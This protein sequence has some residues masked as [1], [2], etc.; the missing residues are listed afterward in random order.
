MNV[1]ENTSDLLLI[2]EGEPEPVAAQPALDDIVE[3][4]EEDED[5]DEDFDP[6]KCAEEE[7]DEDE[8][9]DPYAEPVSSTAER[10]QSESDQVD[11]VDIISRRTRSNYNVDDNVNEPLEFPDFSPDLYAPDVDD[12][13]YKSFL[14]GLFADDLNDIFGDDNDDDNDPEFLMDL[15]ALTRA[16]AATAPQPKVT[17]SET[18]RLLGDDA[19]VDVE[20]PDNVTEWTSAI[21]A[22]HIDQIC[23]QMS[24]HVQLLTQTYLMSYDRPAMQK[25][26]ATA[27]QLLVEI[28]W[29]RSNKLAS[30]FNVPNLDGALKIVADN[31]RPTDKKDAAKEVV[32]TSWRQPRLSEKVQQTISENPSAFPCVPLLPQRGF[33]VWVGDRLKTKTIYTKAEDYLIALGLEQFAGM[34]DKH[35]YIHQLL[36]PT[37]TASQIRF[38][39]KNLRRRFEPENAL[40]CFVKNKPLP[41]IMP[42]PCQLEKRTSYDQDF[43]HLPAWLQEAI[44]IPTTNTEPLLDLSEPVASKRQRVHEPQCIITIN[45]SAAIGHAATDSL[46]TAEQTSMSTVAERAEE[47]AEKR[48]AIEDA[49]GKESEVC[50][51]NEGCGSDY[52]EESSAESDADEWSIEDDMAIINTVETRI[53][54]LSATEKYT[55]MCEQLAKRLNRTVASIDQRF[56]LLIQKLNE[57]ATQK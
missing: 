34:S 9:E 37:K 29:Q 8:D 14:D 54:E 45:A 33:G 6:I 55:E 23:R 2:D 49:Q 43:E 20:T 53:S 56:R 44:G 1:D 4:E 32:Q 16:A 11:D 41:P 17:K 3:E 7:D 27:E 21:S 39:I 10:S 50:S 48:D 51:D 5:D 35:N 57:S 31:P 38:H 52:V 40:C 26:A 24:Q 30:T 46:P 42:I 19:V 47:R 13:V 22:E 25:E 18:D 28:G 12:P 36:V 15:E